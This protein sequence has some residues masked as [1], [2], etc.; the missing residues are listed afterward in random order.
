ME[1]SRVL[2]RPGDLILHYEA[3]YMQHNYWSFPLQKKKKKKVYQL[4]WPEQKAP[5]NSK[6]HR[7]LQNCG[8]ST[9]KSFQS[10]Y[11]PTDAQ[12]LP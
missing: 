8:A 11:L 1:I 5:A 4:T 12:E 2:G 10:F 3:Q 9:W 7:S 6:F